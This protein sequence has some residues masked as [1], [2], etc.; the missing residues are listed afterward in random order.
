MERR[1]KA[2]EARR[3]GA[4]ENPKW[5]PQVWSSRVLRYMFHNVK[6]ASLI[7][8]NF[9]RIDRALFSL[10]ARVPSSSEEKLLVGY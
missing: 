3:K 7:V 4:Q 10:F 1:E 2:G 8:L 5:N 6:I 9:R